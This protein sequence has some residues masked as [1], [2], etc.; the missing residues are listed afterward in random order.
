MKTKLFIIIFFLFIQIT[1]SQCWV[2][3]NSNGFNTVGLTSDGNLY[4]W[5][6]NNYGQLGNGSTTPISN[7]SNFSNQTVW[8]EVS[9]SETSFGI[10]QNGTLWVWG[11]DALLP[12]P[13]TLP[14]QIGTDNNWKKV[15]CRYSHSAPVRSLAIK[16]NGTLWDLGNL[17]AGNIITQVGTDND[18]KDIFTGNG[19]SFAIKNNGTLWSWGRNLGGWLGDGTTIDRPMP[20]QIGT[21]NNWKKIS[22]SDLFTFGVKT[23]GTLWFWGG[24]EFGLSNIVPIQVGTDND[25]KD[26][27]TLNQAMLAVKNNGTLWGWG[28]NWHSG[29]GNGTNTA[30]TNLSRIGTDT[31]WNSISAGAGHVTALKI[32]NTLWVWGSIYNGGTLGN[33]TTTSN[34]PINIS[35]DPFLS[36]NEISP[37]KSTIYPN[38]TKDKIYF[39][40][41]KNISKVEVFDMSG[42]LIEAKSDI[43]NSLDVSKLQKGV[44]IIKIFTDKAVYKSRL[45]K[46]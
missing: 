12:S 28:E 26:I 5:G 21:G 20:V 3:I 42:K 25:W 46:N 30:L 6:A 34:V 1:F 19:F 16:T 22:T 41:L 37:N 40:N 39:K 14:I 10:K 38:P 33:G 13:Q 45:I 2:S 7:L 24:F 43:S 44:Y 17:G 27:A 23:D 11:S 31:N 15:S 8:K 35:C 29:F 32:D 18:W 9:I 36:S 4:L